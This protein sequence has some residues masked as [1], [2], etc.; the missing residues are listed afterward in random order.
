MQFDQSF[1]HPVLKYICPFR[2]SR[3]IVRLVAACE[4]K[5]IKYR[6]TEKKVHT[7][8]AEKLSNMQFFLPVSTETSKGLRIFAKVST[9]FYTI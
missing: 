5:G 3:S 6:E 2:V 4:L 8:N 9:M 1:G 7:R